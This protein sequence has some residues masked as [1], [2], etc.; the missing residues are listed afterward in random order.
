MLLTLFNRGFS[1]FEMHASKNGSKNR[2]ANN[3]V[4]KLLCKKSF[5]D[6]THL[7]SLPGKSTS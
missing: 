2:N 5:S 6:L 4:P 3:G 7:N 1:L